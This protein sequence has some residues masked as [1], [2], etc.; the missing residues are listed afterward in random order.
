VRDAYH[1]GPDG[2]EERRSRPCA[3]GTDV[4]AARHDHWTMG[5][6][7][8]VEGKQTGVRVPITNDPRDKR[9]YALQKDRSQLSRAEIEE[10]IGYC[11]RML[12]VGTAKKAR[13]MWV[14]LKS[15]LEALREE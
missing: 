9:F 6:L 15:E 1:A 10:V 7:V 8:I 11:D 2:Q 4:V 3:T 14:E 13:R 5:A 12:E